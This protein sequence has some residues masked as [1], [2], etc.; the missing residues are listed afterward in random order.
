VNEIQSIIARLEQRR[1]DIDRAISA[2]REVEGI[3]PAQ[4]K[5]VA[6]SAV[7][8]SKQHHMSA[9]AR[10]RIGAATKKRWAAKRA[11]QA[12]LAEKPSSASKASRP[13]KSVRKRSAR[14]L[15]AAA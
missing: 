14:S 8:P 7:N 5:P 1:S 3:E 15:A 13:K 6:P 9:A 12:A 10:R 11:G 4:T 2:L